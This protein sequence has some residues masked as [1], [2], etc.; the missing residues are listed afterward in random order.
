MAL[1]AGMGSLDP[2]ELSIPTGWLNMT[3]QDAARRLRTRVAIEI[4]DMLDN[5]SAPMAGGLLP[6]YRWL[7]RIAE[8]DDTAQASTDA[9]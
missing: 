4:A 1:P 2:K 6:I 3:D 8:Q 5:D 7:S 9:D